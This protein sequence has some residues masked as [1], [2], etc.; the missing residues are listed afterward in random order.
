MDEGVDEGI[1]MGMGMAGGRVGGGGRGALPP[2]PEQ[3]RQRGAEEQDYLVEHEAKESARY[4]AL[5]PSEREE[6]YVHPG[7]LRRIKQ[8]MFGV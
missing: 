1:G 3:L 8:W 4:D 6:V 5:T 2:S 7:L